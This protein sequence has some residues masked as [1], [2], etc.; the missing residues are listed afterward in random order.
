M[1]TL[2]TLALAV[3]MLCVGAAGR[4]MVL[5]A[6]RERGLL[7]DVDKAACRAK[8]QGAISAPEGVSM[9]QWQLPQSEGSRWQTTTSTAVCR[10][11]AGRPSADQ[12]P[13]RDGA[14]RMAQGARGACPPLSPR[15]K[16]PAAWVITEAAHMRSHA[17]FEHCSTARAR[18]TSL[19]CPLPPPGGPQ[20][21]V[22]S[23]DTDTGTVAH[24]YEAGH[25]GPVQYA[26]VYNL[27]S[28]GRCVVS[29]GAKDHT[30]VSWERFQGRRRKQ[31]AACSS[32]GVCGMR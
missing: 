24:M 10:A 7:T 30:V 12:L 23:W 26:S 19:S 11:A 25:K 13:R 16:P 18:L 22:Y 28:Y 21:N 8:V 29:C 2:A 1:A 15:R 17:W 9:E 32:R 27:P 6:W 5:R 20:G 14:V 3:S 31:G 4:A